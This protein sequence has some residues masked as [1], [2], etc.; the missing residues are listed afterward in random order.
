[1][2]SDDTIAAISTPAG[3]GGIGVVRLSGPDSIKIA[4]S[5]FRAQS[6]N[7]PGVP[8][9]AQFGRLIDPVTDELIDEVVLTYFKA[10]HSYSGEDVVEIS[11]HGSPIILARVLQLSVD[12]GARV[13]EPGEFTFRAFFNKRVD[14]AQAQAVRDVI[15]AQTQYQARVATKQLE[16]ELSSRITP[17]K[18]ALVEVIVHLESSVEFVE[19]DI[20]PEVASTLIGKLTNAIN[21]L[22]AIA[23]SFAFG[24][25]VK[26]GFDLAI[27][28]RP[29][30]GKSSVFN[31][32]IGADRAIVTELPGTTRDA[33]YESTSISGV[34]V[35][36]I[37]TAGIR[38]TTDLVESIGI[39]RSRSAI[40]DADIS[41]LVLDASSTL[42]IEDVELLDSVPEARRI[43]ALNK[44]DLKNVLDDGMYEQTGANFAHQHDNVMSISAL[45][46]SGFEQLT[47]KIFERLS[48]DA[49]AERD[50]IMLTDARQH[51][52]VQRAIEQLADARNWLIRGELEE[53][54][55]LRLQGALVALGE[56][57]G[58]TLTEDILGQIFATFCIGK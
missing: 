18:N 28:G 46:G 39:T 29:N 11:C 16:G 1:M 7:G 45:T 2:H 41:L 56:I 13:A 50:D 25:F 10:P 8:N 52:A 54:I 57:T 19:D 6:A 32:L 31:R 48:G 30:V 21:A 4:A 36:L 49:T 58:E 38:E 3:R 23:N 9:R 20:S 34:P 14:L 22:T 24:R 37:D 51:A 42:Q 35:R 27:V 33:L 40:A 55:L 43:I 12:R 47:S 53:V 17:L 15:N 44:I 5:F 26:E